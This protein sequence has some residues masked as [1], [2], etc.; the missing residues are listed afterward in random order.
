MGNSYKLKNMDTCL[1]SIV[2]AIYIFKTK[3]SIQEIYFIENLL[4]K[5]QKKFPYASYLLVVSNTDSK[6]CA[7]R[8][9]IYKGE[10]GRPTTVVIGKKVDTHIHLALMGDENNSAYKFVKALISELKKRKIECMAI[11]KGMHIHSKY[12][13]NYMLKQANIV[14]KSN[15][16]NDLL[17]KKEVVKCYL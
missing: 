6:Y 12:F 7:R 17:E 3:L 4:N 14:R 11:P 9:I 5:Y 2:Y 8:K 1:P 16:F 13:I 10:K 15:K